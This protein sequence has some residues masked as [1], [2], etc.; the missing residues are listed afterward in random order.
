MSD[1]MRVC[2][3]CGGPIPEEAPQGLCPKC[4]LQQAAFG[5]EAGQPSESKPVPPSLEELA[6]AFPHLQVIELIGQGGM[7]FVFKARQPK[8]ERFVALKI[9]PQTLALDPAFAERFQR[10]ARVLAKLNHPN[11]VTIFD[12]GYA[13]E[14]FY[15]LMEYVDGVN[16]RQAMKLGRFSPEQALDIVPKICDALHFAHNEGILHRDIKPE[17]ILL[18]SRGRVKIADFGIAKILGTETAGETKVAPQPQQNV[19]GVVGT[20]NYMAPEQLE[21][22]HKVDQRADIYSLGV[23]FYEMLTGE[24]PSGSVVPPSKKATVDPRVDDVVMRTLEKERERRQKT[25]DEVRTQV[26]TIAETPQQSSGARPFSGQYD[27]KSKQTIFG[28]PWVHVTWGFDGD[29]PRKAKGVIAVGPRAVGIAAVGFE[30][31]GF[32]TFGMLSV[33]L[34]PVGVVSVGAFA[35]GLLAVGLQATG[36]FAAGV[37]TTALVTLHSGLVTAITLVLAFVALRYWRHELFRQLKAASTH[38]LSPP[39]PNAAAPTARPDTFWRKFAI[40]IA[41]LIAAPFLIALIAIAAAIIYPALSHGK[42]PR[43]PQAPVAPSA[44]RPSRNVGRVFG[45]VHEQTI[46]SRESKVDC[47]FDIDS[48]KLLTPS[49][50]V[51]EAIEKNGKYEGGFSGTNAERTWETRDI[52]SRDVRAYRYVQWIRETGADLLYMGNGRIIAFDC[53]LSPAH[54]NSST[55]WEDLGSLSAPEVQR[56]MATLKWS[57]AVHDAQR[58]GLPMPEPPPEGG[59]Y[60]SAVQLDSTTPN[61]PRVNEITVQQSRLWHFKT[62]RGAEG[63][64]EIVESTDNPPAVKISYRLLEAPK[65]I[66]PTSSVVN[67]E[68]PAR[69]TASFARAEKQFV[70]DTKGTWYVTITSETPLAEN[71]HLVAVLE[72]ADGSLRTQNFMTSTNASSK[73][74]SVLRW[75]VPGDDAGFSSA[76]AQEA[77]VQTQ[78]LELHPQYLVAGTLLP[79]FSVTNSAGGVIK[80][81]IEFHRHFA[82]P[83]GEAHMDQIA[84][85]TK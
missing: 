23:V 3:K 21:T 74:C 85:K 32:M 49:D 48:G 6:L 20:P 62:K 14:F 8:L 5:T 68:F 59:V 44:P 47:F 67:P 64:L 31:F 35:V 75:T 28:V 26:E 84:L 51:V 41:G 40:I 19:T 55:N 43:G 16:L 34:N 7:G 39:V 38:P 73:P 82:Q 66:K 50:A 10:E 56:A 18:D 27:F 25:A 53:F 63:V 9:L 77:L 11:I 71:E 24:L 57:Q 83:V 81:S 30:A 37:Q 12:F 80:G 72:M 17:N 15:L 76:N 45:P 42:H 58:K 69:K 79:A 60:G 46:Q 54:G 78:Q 36:L 33:G 4:V 29:Q 22:P 13:G 61:G 1:T 2:P 52:E 70:N 65:K